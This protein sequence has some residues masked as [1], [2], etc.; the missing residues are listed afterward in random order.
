MIRVDPN[1][2]C[3]WWSSP[4][5]WK[6]IGVF[7]FMV[8]QQKSLLFFD[9]GTFLACRSGLL[10]VWEVEQC[11]QLGLYYPRMLQDIRVAW[12]SFLSCTG[13]SRLCDTCVHSGIDVQQMMPLWHVASFKKDRIPLLST[14]KSSSPLAIGQIFCQFHRLF[15]I[16]WAFP[17]N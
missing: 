1:H 6:I 12:S 2:H 17:R 8:T 14:N 3:P 7:I 16:H 15:L 13:T 9:W 4:K 11:C 10:S 5:N